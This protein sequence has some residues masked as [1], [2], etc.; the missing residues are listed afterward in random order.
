MKDQVAYFS[1]LVAC[2][3]AG[4]LLTLVAALRA[5]GLV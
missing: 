5:L 4:L 2:V 3:S 1:I